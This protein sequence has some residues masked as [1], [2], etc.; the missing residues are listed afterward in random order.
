[1]SLQKRM[2][3]NWACTVV[4][5]RIN[6]L[7]EAHIGDL[8]ILLV[9]SQLEAEARELRVLLSCHAPSLGRHERHP[10]PYSDRA[11]NSVTVNSGGVAL[12]LSR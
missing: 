7:H 1:M 12:N 6:I 10:M 5:T 3:D 9:L 4:E 11:Y 8:N 2:V